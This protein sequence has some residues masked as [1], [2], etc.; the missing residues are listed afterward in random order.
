MSAAGVGSYVLSRS[1]VVEAKPGGHRVALHYCRAMFELDLPALRQVRGPALPDMPPTIQLDLAG[2][3]YASFNNVP[4]YGPFDVKEILAQDVVAMEWETNHCFAGNYAD[5]LG[6]I[7]A[8]ARVR[9]K[10]DT[11]SSV[12]IVGQ[13]K[14][15]LP[16]TMVNSLYFDMA[17]PKLG[18][19]VFNQDPISLRGVARNFDYERDVLGDPRVKAHRDGVADHLK[20]LSDA[21]SPH[22]EPFG[23]HQLIRPVDFY[24]REQPSRRVLRLVETQIETLPHYGLDIRVI[25]KKIDGLMLTAKLEIVNL[26]GRP[27][28]IVWYV[29][30]SHELT[31]VSERSGQ[32]KI[33]NEPIPITVQA[34]NNNPGAPLG[35]KACIFCGAANTPK[36]RARFRLESVSAFALLQ[37]RDFS[38]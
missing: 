23:T 37:G 10:S 7:S 22:F 4:I 6:I 28:E 5:E 25:S 9:G 32:T 29:D 13:G 27:Q 38:A 8:S 18:L 30:D 34:Y 1:S 3:G 21:K 26:S 20:A 2:S 11:R 33:A 19:K 15:P 35:E 31:V 12:V 16:G 36:D 17:I 14:T 24:L